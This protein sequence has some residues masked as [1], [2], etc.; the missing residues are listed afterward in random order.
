MGNGM[1][2]FPI[3]FGDLKSTCNAIRKEVKGLTKSNEALTHLCNVILSKLVAVEVNTK[4][5][6]PNKTPSSGGPSHNAANTRRGSRKVKAETSPT[7][8]DPTTFNSVGTIMIEVSDDDDDT[9]VSP[10]PMSKKMDVG[11]CSR[12]QERSPTI[13]FAKGSLSKSNYRRG[14]HH[15]M[16]TK[17]REASLKDTASIMKSLN[18]NTSTSASALKIPKIEPGLKMTPRKRG[19]NE[20][21]TVT[22]VDDYQNVLLDEYEEQTYVLKGSILPKSL[23]TKFSP[24]T[25][26]G[27][28]PEEAQL[29]LYIF[30]MNGDQNEL[31]MKSEHTMAYR[32]DFECL[33]PGNK[34]SNEI[35]TLMARKCTWMQQHVTL[36][37]TWSLPPK[38]AHD[39]CEGATVG[40]HVSDYV[41][42]WMHS[43]KDL[44]HIYIPIEDIQNHWYL[45]VISVDQHIIYHLDSH[46]NEADVDRRHAT[47]RT[48]GDF[49]SK[50]VATNYYPPSFGDVYMNLSDWE[51]MEALGMLN[52]GQRMRLALEFITGDHNEIKTKLQ[53]KVDIFCRAIGYNI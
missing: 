33:C 8:K 52:T 22:G 44:K 17:F 29:S 24:T 10:H 23:P 16:Q 2:N 6:S 49:I 30:Y 43:F 19:S 42:E 15:Q 7:I 40:D 25:D 31:L 41:F 37:T 18:F 21:N 39:I 3:N 13:G 9:F 45:M 47:M 38:F 36:Q 26:M 48:I 14:V 11:T 50:I 4:N 35:I 1:E 46:L 27:L 34:I 5:K 20:Q 28:T 12:S 32:R 53:E 51:I